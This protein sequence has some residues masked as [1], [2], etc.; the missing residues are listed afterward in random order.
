MGTGWTAVVVDNPPAVSFLC[1][2]ALS[3]EADADRLTIRPS[4]SVNPPVFG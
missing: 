3:K 2:E 1:P 4:T